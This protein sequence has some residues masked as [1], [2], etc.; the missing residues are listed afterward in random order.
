[1]CRTAT[2]YSNVTALFLI[3][4]LNLKSI[5]I[6]WANIQIFDISAQ[7]GFASFSYFLT[8]F[9]DNH[10]LLWKVNSCHISPHFSTCTINSKVSPLSITP[11]HLS[12]N[13]TS[14][15]YCG[16]LL[17]HCIQKQT[18]RAIAEVFFTIS[19]VIFAAQKSGLVSI[20]CKLI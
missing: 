12:M 6:Y 15:C 20:T 2:V 11:M 9:S 14:Q 1:M 10:I 4:R 18:H 16:I 8:Y 13:C 17:I 3:N 5:L 19:K 7:E